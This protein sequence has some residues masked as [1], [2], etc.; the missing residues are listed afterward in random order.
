MQVCKCGHKA[1]YHINR[2]SR[3]MACPECKTFEPAAASE[4]A[5]PFSVHK[6][7]PLPSRPYICKECGGMEFQPL[8]GNVDA[9]WNPTP[10]TQAETE[11]TPLP[12]LRFEIK[13]CPIPESGDADLPGFLI[14]DASGKELAHVFERYS[15]KL[16]PD[17]ET[18]GRSIV[19]ACSSHE[20]LKAENQRLRDALG[21]LSEK[22]DGDGFR[23]DLSH[24]LP[25]VLAQVDAALS[26]TDVT[27]SDAD[28]KASHKELVEALKYIN[29]HCQLYG[30]ADQA[31]EKVDAALANAAKLTEVNHG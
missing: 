28:L 27:P 3:C 11:H 15:N 5:Q 31:R 25:A 13:P 2:K 7:I 1:G 9:D 23:K 16:A 14:D 21:K 8:H 20:A 26:G 10:P 6:Y 30:A 19:T 29:F 12:K 4:P 18:L 24:D 22:F 17:Y